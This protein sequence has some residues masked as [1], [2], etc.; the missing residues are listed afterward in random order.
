[1]ADTTLF[2]TSMDSTVHTEEFIKR[3]ITY[4]SDNNNGNYNGSITFDCSPIANAGKFASFSEAYLEVPLVITLR[5]DTALAGY[6]ALKAPF[7]AA[8]KAG[9]HHLIN[10]LSVEYNNVGVTQLSSFTNF[11]VSYKLM[12]TWSESD[13]K[14]HGGSIYFYPD[15][16]CSATFN[17]IA[18]NGGTGNGVCNNSDAGT[19]AEA[20]FI[21]PCDEGYKSEVVNHGLWK[22]QQRMCYDPDCTATEAINFMDAATCATIGK[23]YYTDSGVAGNNGIKVWYVMAKID[24]KNLSDFF[25]K[26]PLLKGGF[27]KVTL[28]TNTASHNLQFECT[29]PGGV[30]AF[31]NLIQTSATITGATTPL[32]FPSAKDGTNNG[33]AG[34]GALMKGKNAAIN[35]T[36]NYAIAIGRTTVSGTSLSHPTFSGCRMVIPLYTMDP[37]KE[38]QYFTVN[39]TKTIT[40]TDIFSYRINNVASKASFDNLITNGISKPTKVV[41]I[42]FVNSAVAEQNKFAPWESVFDTAPAQPSPGCALSQL[43][44]R[45]GGSPVWQQNGVYDY[46]Q[47]T[48]EL[49]ASNALNGGLVDGLTSGLIDETAFQMGYRYYVCD[50]SRRL[51]SET[52]PLSVQ[53]SGQNMSLKAIDIIVFVEHERSITLDL[54]SGQKLA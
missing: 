27:I 16:A 15:S 38:E 11:H 50:V 33:S 48:N 19:T 20:N 12:T 39:R 24:L 42:P 10:S 5:A 51:S 46:E 6:A 2:D 26:L 25:D 54:L 34:I 53:V 37:I 41:M 28:N 22:R 23:D 40:Y 36:M 32:M 7:A 1:M 3:E 14:K 21:P 13:V 8:L 49:K 44:I 31:T 4:L 47:F 43:N 17:P 18:N 9:T 45:I 29:A 35:Y 52:A 30:G